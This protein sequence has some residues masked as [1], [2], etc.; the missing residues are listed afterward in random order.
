MSEETGQPGNYQGKGK[1]GEV[2]DRNLSLSHS[3][4]QAKGNCHYGKL[5]GPIVLREYRSSHQV[6]KRVRATQFMLTLHL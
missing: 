3:M 5:S 6:I 2:A 4:T 1:T